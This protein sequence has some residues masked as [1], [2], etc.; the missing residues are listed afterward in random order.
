MAAFIFVD[1]KKPYQYVGLQSFNTCCWCL[2][3]E[4]PL[5]P[6]VLEDFLK[7]SMIGDLLVVEFHLR[8]SD[9]AVLTSFQFPVAGWAWRFIS[10]PQFLGVEDWV[11][12]C[13]PLLRIHCGVLVDVSRQFPT[14]GWNTLWSNSWFT[15]LCSNRPNLAED[16][17]WR[18]GGSLTPNSLVSVSP[19]PN[20]LQKYFPELSWTWHSA[21]CFKESGCKKT[22]RNS[23]YSTD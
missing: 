14:A 10:P 15:G 5:F 3:C 8:P 22:S 12:S 7:V 21:Y 16:F 2:F 17:S 6:Q 1:I 11:S 18:W 4:I 23:W 19:L 9:L 13:L 20:L